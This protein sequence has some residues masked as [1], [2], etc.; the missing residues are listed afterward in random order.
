MSHEE[1]FA[2]FG[3]WEYVPFDRNGI[4]RS[5]SVE[6]VYQAFKARLIEELRADVYEAPLRA[7]LFDPKDES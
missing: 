7:R 6:Q 3:D 5:H 4:D 1:F 2:L